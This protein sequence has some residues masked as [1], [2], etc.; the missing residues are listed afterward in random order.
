M[1]ALGGWQKI[2]EIDCWILTAEPQIYRENPRYTRK[3]SR[4]GLDRTDRDCA[5]QQSPLPGGNQLAVWPAIFYKM[6]PPLRWAHCSWPIQRVLWPS[7]R[8]I[9]APESSTP[10]H[11]RKHCRDRA[12]SLTV[13]A[14]QINSHSASSSTLAFAICCIKMSS[15]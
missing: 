11:V 6:H 10:I 14:V 1:L 9:L 13:S 7:A 12:R 15:S 3:D 8:N 4:F 5:V 2:D